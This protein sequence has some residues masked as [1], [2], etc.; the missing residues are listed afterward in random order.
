MPVAAISSR[1][2]DPI[3][4]QFFATI[5]LCVDSKLSQA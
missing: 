1:D 2:E 4:S 5:R 3:A